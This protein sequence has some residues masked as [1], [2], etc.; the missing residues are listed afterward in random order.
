[1]QHMMPQ[2]MILNQI[3]DTKDFNNVKMQ[4]FGV[5]NDDKWKHENQLLLMI[6]LRI[7][8]GKGPPLG[9]ESSLER[10]RD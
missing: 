4:T 5:I 8:M 6:T 1:M 7:E 3:F 2:D 10:E 9:K